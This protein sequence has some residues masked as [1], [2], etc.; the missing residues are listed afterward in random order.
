MVLPCRDDRQTPASSIW[1]PSYS[2][3]NG[4]VSAD[5]GHTSHRQFLIVLP[6][7]DGGEYLKACVASILAQI[8][9]HFRLVVLENASTDDTS[10]WL[11]QLRD[12]RVSVRESPAPLEIEKNWARILQLDLSEEFLTIIGHDDLLDP[13]YLSQMSALIDAH[14]D[15][16][17]YQSH[18]RLID[19]RGRRLRSCLPMP[20]RETAEGFLAARLR[21]R[22]DSHGTG[23]MFRASDY[24]RVGGI[25]LYKKLIFADDALWLDLMRGSYKATLARE[26]FS[27]RLHPGGTSHSP[28]WRP[29]LDALSCYL[30]FLKNY[31]RS[32]RGVQSALQDGL[33]DYLTF[34]FRWAYF[35]ADRVHGERPEILHTIES[36]SVKAGDI[37]ASLGLPSF[38]ERVRAALCDRMAGWRWFFWLLDRHLR[39]RLQSM[40][41]I[42][43]R[44]P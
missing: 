38:R 16:G 41:R 7:R 1:H 4:E 28:D 9:E 18:Y 8:H 10:S 20:A 11:R 29:T 44:G 35:S 22:R 17:L 25:P 37:E 23:Y 24:V 14:P 31:G 39:I 26:M 3:G 34:W 5:R 21:L 33:A 42:P 15:A 19:K 36:L 30:D 32:D 2:I 6:V 27:Y 12:P 43:L 40:N 13:G